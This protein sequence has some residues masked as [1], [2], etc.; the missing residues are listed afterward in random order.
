MS[1]TSCI[2]VGFSFATDVGCKYLFLH[3][4]SE[5]VNVI[6][7]GTPMTLLPIIIGMS[8][9]IGGGFYENY[10]SRDS[11]FPPTVFRDVTT[12]KYLCY[13]PHAKTDF[14]M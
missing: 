11:L 4:G 5:C 12:G 3:N 14:G 1:A 13:R 10:R 8:V 2:I 6:S 9:L 7:G